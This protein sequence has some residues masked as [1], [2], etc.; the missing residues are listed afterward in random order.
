[1]NKK[2]VN[3][4]RCTSLSP[5]VP[6]LTPENTHL[7]LIIRIFYS[8]YHGCSTFLPVF[9]AKVDTYDVL[10][11]RSPFCVNAIC[12][13][14]AKVKNGGSEFP[15]LLDSSALIHSFI[16]RLTTFCLILELK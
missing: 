2:H 12:M 14:A 1:M 3:C 7:T 4:S 8:F 16:R 11:R 10:H 13:V 6:P 15:N 5:S 9:D